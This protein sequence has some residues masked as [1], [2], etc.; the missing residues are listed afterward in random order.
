MKEDALQREEDR[1]E[2]KIERV[3]LFKQARQK[4]LDSLPTRREM[5]Q[6][7]EQELKIVFNLTGNY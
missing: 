7:S 5:E 6:M 1:K 3:E 2:L 4:I